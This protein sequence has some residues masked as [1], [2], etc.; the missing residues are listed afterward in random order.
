MGNTLRQLAFISTFAM[1]DSNKCQA[2]T[3]WSV[4]GK[5]KNTRA[6]QDGEKSCTKIGVDISSDYLK[7]WKQVKKEEYWTKYNK[8]FKGT[9]DENK[10]KKSIFGSTQTIIWELYINK[11]VKIFTRIRNGFKKEKANKIT[12]HP[13]SPKF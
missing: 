3:K 12:T 7:Q 8:Y 13:F 5:K 10:N 1:P 11:T 2:T 6:S 4:A 9:G